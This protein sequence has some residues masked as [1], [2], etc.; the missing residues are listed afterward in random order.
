[1][2]ELQCIHGNMPRFGQWNIHAVCYDDILGNVS[3]KEP[4]VE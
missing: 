1:M 3:A 4:V 2:Y